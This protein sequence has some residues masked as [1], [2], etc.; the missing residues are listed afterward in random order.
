MNLIVFCVLLQAIIFGTFAGYIA[1][2]KGRGPGEW[3]ALGFLFSL[4]AIL[5]L[6]ALPKVGSEAK[7]E[8]GDQQPNHPQGSPASPI[9]TTPIFDGQ[10]SIELPEYQLFLTRRYNIERNNTLEKFVVGDKIFESLSASLVYADACYQ[11]DLNEREQA[12]AEAASV[13]ELDQRRKEE[14]AATEQQR[15]ESE[16]LLNESLEKQRTKDASDLKKMLILFVLMV[17]V[18]ASVVAITVSIG[19]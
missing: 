2:E 8:A 12:L 16:R 18:I 9:E 4:L 11:R 7:I 6:I 1:K 17:T 3:F 15:R 5:A 10:R 14:E 19:K 13:R